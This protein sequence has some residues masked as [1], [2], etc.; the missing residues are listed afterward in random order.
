[1]FVQGRVY[2]R[3]DLH[4]LYGGQ[5]EGEIS[6]PAGRPYIEPHHIRRLSD[7]GQD[8]PR[9]VAGV[10]PNCHRRAHYSSDAAVYNDRLS[11]VVAALEQELP[12]A[13]NPVLVPVK[14]MRVQRQHLEPAVRFEGTT[15]RE[16]TTER[17]ACSHHWVIQPTDGSVSSGV[18]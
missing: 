15:M 12:L 8:H 18:C 4:G 14:P 17:R 9:W 11:D 7:G 10:C 13:P 1:M 6:T 3:R 5:R 16:L 2:R